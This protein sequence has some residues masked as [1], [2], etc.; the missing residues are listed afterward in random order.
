VSGVVH[1]PWYA[2]G[3]RAEQLRAELERI[4]P[5]AFRYGATG[6]AVHQ[7]RDDKY[8]LLQMLEFDEHVDWERWW[9]SPE[10]IDFRTFC[11][12]W[13]QVP[14]LYVWNTLVCEGR[15]PQRVGAGTGA[16]ATGNGH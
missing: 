16:H 10:M 2:T 3:F 9:I 6:Y 15:V 13:F 11:Q 8:K 14:V 12:G 1:I 7:S 5:L 4:S